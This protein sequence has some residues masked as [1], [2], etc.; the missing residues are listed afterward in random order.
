MTNLFEDKTGM[1]GRPAT[2]ADAPAVPVVRERSD[3]PVRTALTLREFHETQRADDA[4][5][6]VNCAR[7]RRGHD[8]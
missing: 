3:A 4:M 8:Y 6:V 2:T 1:P 5:A 7:P